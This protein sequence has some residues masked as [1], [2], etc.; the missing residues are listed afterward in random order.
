MKFLIDNALSPRISDQLKRIGYDALHV[1]DLGLA[2]ASDKEIFQRAFEDDRIIISADSDFGFLLSKWN[3]Q[4]P[5]VILFRKGIEVN[6]EE[7]IKILLSNLE[8]ISFALLEGHVIIFEPNK[9]R[10]RKLPFFN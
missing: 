9:I 3:Q 1:R 8:K 6:P 2:T 4:K 10:I 5:S 7:Q